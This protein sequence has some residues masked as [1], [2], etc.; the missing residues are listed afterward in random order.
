MLMCAESGMRYYVSL[1]YDPWIALIILT[2]D[3]IWAGQRIQ[4]IPGLA[5]GEREVW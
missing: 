5:I 1:P 3:S 2:G 4:W